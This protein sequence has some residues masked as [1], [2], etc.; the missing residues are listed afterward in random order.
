MKPVV[1]LVGRPN[2]GKSTLFNRMTRSRD[3]IVDDMPGVTRDRHFGDARWEDKSFILVDTGGFLSNDADSFASHIRAQV[4]L[5]LE[6]ADYVVLVVDGKSGISYYDRDLVELLRARGKS[7]F[8][9]VNKI[10]GEK[11][12]VALNDFYALGVEEPFPLS[13]EHGYGF[14]DFMDVL[15]ADM[16]CDGVDEGIQPEGPVRVAVV[17]RP[18]A[19][20]SSLI[21]RLL[22]EER[23]VVSEV[24]G[25][26]R[27]SV[28][29]LVRFG[30]KSYLFIDT[31]GIRRKGKVTHRVEK[32]SV[33]K[34]LKSLE[35]CE[36]A[37]VL[38]DAAEGVTDQ[39]VR[40]AGY[41]SDRGCGCIFVCNKWDL[42]PPEKKDVKRMKEDIGMEAKFLGY[43]PVLT[44]SA[45][46]GQR[47]TKLFPMID[48]VHEQYITQVSTSHLN[49]IIEDATARTEPSLHNGKRIKFYFASQV[50]NAP[51]TFA[52]VTNYPDAIHFSYKRYLVN[53]IREA[54]GL[55]MTPIRV[56]F[57]ERSGRT[58]YSGKKSKPSP[59]LL[60]KLQATRRSRK[61]RNR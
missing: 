23:M 60:K 27:D 34:A 25:T 4:E 46:T 11:H 61:R 53:Q 14:S 51:P 32:Y 54:L 13:A 6:D 24:A 49:R 21:N 48:K 2:V 28:D 19:G 15:T 44:I 47:V 38:L 29:S 59:A 1:A 33:I 43:A 58:D 35:R 30:G 22:G 41:A 8:C 37:L 10:D 17:G 40:V 45:L 5:A 7:F 50:K 42:V 20:K 36:V 39:D 55:D 56:E 18:N 57:R 31:A 9:L 16:P 3:A 12:E 52:L 26:T